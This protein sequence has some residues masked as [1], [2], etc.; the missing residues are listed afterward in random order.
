M[1]NKC[2]Y[3]DKCNKLKYGY[4]KFHS[5]NEYNDI[6]QKLNKL[7]ISD[8]KLTD[9]NFPKLGQNIIDNKINDFIKI[10]ND[11]LEIK[12]SLIE[13]LKKDNFIKNDSI[14]KRNI[15]G[16][17]IMNM[18]KKYLS[19]DDQMKYINKAVGMI[20]DPNIFDDNDMINLIENEKELLNYFNEAI[21]QIKD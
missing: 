12:K 10:L 5:I 7:K 1:N 4:C 16:T 11:E 13:I 20:I 18:L 17:I 21:E 15:Y 14:Y 3:A 9:N 6:I 2:Y 19:E 8:N